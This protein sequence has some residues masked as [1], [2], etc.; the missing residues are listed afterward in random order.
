MCC[1]IYELDVF[2]RLFATQN[3][4]ASWYSI[5][6]CQ[7]IFAPP[8]SGYLTIKFSIFHPPLPP[9]PQ[10]LPTPILLGTQEYTNLNM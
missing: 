2:C 5:L 8:H 9:T 7:I 4:S 6:T 10:I 3:T 1:L